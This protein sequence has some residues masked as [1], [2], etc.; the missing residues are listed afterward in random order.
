MDR[1]PRFAIIEA[2]RARLRRK[3]RDGARTMMRAGVASLASTL[4]F[5]ASLALPFAWTLTAVLVAP[6]VMGTT[7]G[8]VVV[9][10]RR[11]RQASH[12]LRKI[13]PDALMPAAKLLV[14]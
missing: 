2:E 11:R 5:A 6:L 12:R 13:S 9:G 10:A 7:L 4:V 1:D 3:Q 8:M 14:R